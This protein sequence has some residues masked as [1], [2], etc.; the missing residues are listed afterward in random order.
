MAAIIAARDA[1]GPFE[2]IWDFCRRVDQAQVNKRAL[3][4]LIRSRRP[5]LAPAPPASGC[6]RR[7]P[8]RSRPGRPAPQR[9]GGRPGVAVRRDGRRRGRRRDG[10]ARPA[11][12]PAR[13]AARRAAGGREGGARPLRLEP[14][15]P[16]LPPAARPRG[17]LRPRRRSPTAPTTRRSPSA[18]IIGAVKNITTRRGEPM[19]FI[20]LDDLEGSVEVVVVP[21]VLTEA[22]DLLAADAHGRDR[23]A[24][25]TRRGR[26]RPSSSPRSS[27]PSPPRRAP[28]RSASWCRVHV[29]RLAETH[30]GELRRLLVDH[31]GVGAGRR[32][33]PDRGRPPPAAPRRGVPGRSAGERPRSRAEDP[34]RRALSGLTIG[35]PHRLTAARGP[36][37]NTRVPRIDH[38]CR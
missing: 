20:R 25:S 26:A 27:R 29:S 6:S 35:A 2:S 14:P 23:R 24:G 3:E 13:D 17:H 32:G 9:H 31:R 1:G 5:R 21:A 10:R 11:D 30:L 19:M 8:P 38:P 37:F 34:F 18:G 16:G 12:R 28:R 15:A 7:S 33:R 36:G 22:R 4:S